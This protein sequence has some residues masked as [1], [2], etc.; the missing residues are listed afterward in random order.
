MNQE[1]SIRVERIG[2]DWIRFVTY[3]AGAIQGHY[4]SGNK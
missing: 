2:F 3:V 4:H 1:E